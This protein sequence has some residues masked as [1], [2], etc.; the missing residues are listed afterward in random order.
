MAFPT[1]TTASPANIKPAAFLAV[2]IMDPATSKYQTLGSIADG[3][4]NIRSYSSPDSLGRNKSNGATEFT[5]K[6]K[7]KQASSFELGLLDLICSGTNA[8]LFKLSDAG[9]IPT[10]AAVTAGWVLVGPSQVGVKAKVVCDGTPEECRYI[11]LEWQGSF[12]TAVMDA[13]VK[14]SIDDNQFAS[15]ADSA[16]A[17]FYAIGTYTATL[18]GGS[19]KIANIKPNGVTAIT[20][21]DAN[22]AGAQT[23]SPIANVKM[24]FEM[25]ATQDGMRRF[26]PNALDVNVEYDW[27]ATDAADLLHIPDFTAADVNVT[28]MMIDSVMFTLSNQ[29]GIE[30]NYEVSGDMDKARV[31]RF[32]HKGKVLQSAFDNILP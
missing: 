11:E 30:T 2:Y 26:L 25:L 18:D 31:V 16:T 8:F 17:V 28:L 10:A 3:V 23:L 20:I 24:S 29:V 5:A 32:T 12:L 22:S 7:M 21:E 6:C 4:M 1:V 14:A 9:A 15:S 19:P 13:V 27:M